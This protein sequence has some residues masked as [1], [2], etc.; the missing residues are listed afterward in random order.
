M[1]Y[2]S[3][4]IYLLIYL[5][6]WISFS[7]YLLYPNWNSNFPTEIVKLNPSFT[8]LLFKNVGKFVVFRA[9]LIAMLLETTTLSHYLLLCDPDPSTFYASITHQWNQASNC[10]ASSLSK[11]TFC[12]DWWP[13]TN[14]LHPY[15]MRNKIEGYGAQSCLIGEIKAGIVAA[16]G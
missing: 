3:I 6:G 5:I 12:Q 8:A 1:D 10:G 9:L 15:A 14:S 13:E 4:H 16:W 11:G 7:L 2:T